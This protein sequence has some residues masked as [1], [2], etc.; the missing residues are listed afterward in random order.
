MGV[1]SPP[2]GLGQA[3]HHGEEEEGERDI[4]EIYYTGANN[5]SSS[6][7]ELIFA[8]TMIFIL[9]SKNCILSSKVNITSTVFVLS[10]GA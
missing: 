10:Q 1:T 8:I 3:V 9:N 5:N 6:R 2:S 7:F 4:G